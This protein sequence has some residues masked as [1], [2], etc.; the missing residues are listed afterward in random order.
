MLGR[1][2]AAQAMQQM[3]NNRRPGLSARHI[4]SI[5]RLVG[6]LRPR[7]KGKTGGDE[8]YHRPKTRHSRS[9]SESAKTKLRNRRSNHPAG[10]APGN[11]RE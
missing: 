9:N 4:E 2:S 5:R 3:E 8:I 10:K 11:L 1:A 6:Y 7:L